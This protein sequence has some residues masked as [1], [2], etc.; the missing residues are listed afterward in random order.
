[1]IGTVLK[2]VDDIANSVKQGSISLEDVMKV[3]VVGDYKVSLSNMLG[4][5]NLNLS[6]EKVERIINNIRDET[7]SLLASHGF[8]TDL[9]NRFIQRAMYDLS[10]SGMKPDI[11]IASIDLS[12]LATDNGKMLMP[13]EGKR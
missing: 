12:D 9:A 8:D 4:L 6:A 3:Q 2:G 5:S 7:Q 13:K 11:H 10:T 1:M